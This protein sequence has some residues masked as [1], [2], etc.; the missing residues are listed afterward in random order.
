MLTVRFL[1]DPWLRDQPERAGRV[2][3][4]L[5]HC[6]FGRGAPSFRTATGFA[7]VALKSLENLPAVPILVISAW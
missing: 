3:S 5:S 4:G 1:E 7:L 6:Y 2:T